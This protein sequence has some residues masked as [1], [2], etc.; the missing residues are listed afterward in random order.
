MNGLIPVEYDETEIKN[1]ENALRSRFVYNSKGMAH[2]SATSNVEIYYNS[3]LYQMEGMFNVAAGT[4]TCDVPLGNYLYVKL[5]SISDS[6]LRLIFPS[7]SSTSTQVGL[8][9]YI[10]GAFAPYYAYI[11]RTSTTATTWYLICTRYRC[12]SSASPKTVTLSSALKLY[13]INGARLKATVLP[14]PL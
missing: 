14:T 11:V 3:F 5:A 10:T 4:Y 1:Y 9:Y 6:D 2:I 8:G 12:S 13:W 7:L